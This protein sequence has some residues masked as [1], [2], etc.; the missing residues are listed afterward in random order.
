MEDS[1]IR[2]GITQGDTNG[3]G[4]ELIFKALS[5]PTILEICTPIIYGNPKV[6]AY[7]RKS[8][9]LT[10]NYSTIHNA[11]D[12]QP[13]RINLVVCDDEDVKIEFGQS[14]LEAGQQALKSLEAAIRDWKD[15]KFD[16]LVTAPINNNT[17]QSDAFHFPGHTEYI[18]ASAGDGAEAMMVLMNGRIR[19]ALVTSHLPLR[20]VADAVTEEAILSKLRIFNESLKRDFRHSRPRIAVL[21]LNP[22]AG[23][24]GL[25]GKE[26][27]TVIVPAMKK[28]EEEGITTFGPY[29]ADT[30]FG[31]C[32]Y[33]HFDGVLAMYYDQGLTGF[34][35]IAMGDGVNYTAGLPIVRTCPDHGVAYDIAGQNKADEDSFR[36]AIYTAI[37]VWKNRQEYD[38]EHENPLEKL[39][40]D[41]REDDRRGRRPE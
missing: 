2:V 17:I 8:A 39:Y 41:R 31:L 5:D 40:H 35:A 18:Q 34:K 32:S 36:Q 3:V 23:D 4:Y 16:V 33:D 24:K 6:A 27:E 14:A 9:E 12:A 28:A 19:V 7:H 1:R 38:E 15:D 10:T 25:M 30:F 22:H 21:S 26:E 29:P 20:E 37:D 11:S 13:D